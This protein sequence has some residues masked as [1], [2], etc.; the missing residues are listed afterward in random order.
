MRPIADI[1]RARRRAFSRN[2]REE[3]TFKGACVVSLRRRPPVRGATCR[4]SARSVARGSCPSTIVGTIDEAGFVDW[5]FNR[6]R[7][8][9]VLVER[10][11]ASDGR[12][13]PGAGRVGIEGGAAL[14]RQ[15][16]SVVHVAA[17]GGSSCGERRGGVGKALAGEG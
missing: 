13:E 1:L 15:R 10:R 4:D 6:E 7:A 17:S 11:E 2:G 14:R 8:P 12:R 16:Q 3:I 5:I 9:A